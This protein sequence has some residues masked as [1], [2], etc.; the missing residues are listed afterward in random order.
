MLWVDC[1]VGPAGMGVGLWKDR[2]V[3]HT[4]FFGLGIN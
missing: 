3:L 1:W 2:K 4:Q